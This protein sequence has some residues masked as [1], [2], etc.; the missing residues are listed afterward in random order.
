MR[1]TITEN[2]YN[3]SGL[4]LSIPEKK[5]SWN[6]LFLLLW[7]IWFLIQETMPICIQENAAKVLSDEKIAMVLKVKGKVS[8]YRK[9]ETVSTC[10]RRGFYLERR[11]KL[12]TGKNSF[13]AVR[14]LANSDLVRI[15]PN[16]ICLFR[17][18]KIENSMVDN[19]YKELVTILARVFRQT[20]V[21]KAAKPTSV[22]AVK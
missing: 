9:N 6:Y 22:A 13:V 18:R 17:G 4:C 5:D 8:L 2:N 16:S 11:D 14:F 1:L 7:I 12:I 19:I 10:L 15:R 3:G 21:R 20:P